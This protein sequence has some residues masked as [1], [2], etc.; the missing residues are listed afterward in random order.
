[1]NPV[2]PQDPPRPLRLNR[3]VRGR[4]VTGH[5]ILQVYNALRR[6]EWE[7]N[8]EVDKAVHNLMASS[9]KGGVDSTQFKAKKTVFREASQKSEGGQQV[10]AVMAG[11]KCSTYQYLGSMQMKVRCCGGGGGVDVFVAGWC[12][13]S[14]GAG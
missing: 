1:M 11:W 10:Q 6:L 14:G 9:N 7:T 3:F 5:H 8:R 13:D 12:I 2:Q 4:F